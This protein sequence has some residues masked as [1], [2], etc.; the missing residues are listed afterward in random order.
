MPYTNNRW[1]KKKPKLLESA[2][3]MY[4]TT[5]SGEKILD[6]VAG[7][8][9][10]NVGYGRERL[11]KIAYEQLSLL[12]YYNSFFKTTTP[13][14]IALSKKLVEITP[15]EFNHVFFTNVSNYLIKIIKYYYN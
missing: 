11:A 4:Y 13:P 12:P 1:F 5:S 2:K 9:C 15:K 7:L 6:A 14:T 3:G 10:V 8:W